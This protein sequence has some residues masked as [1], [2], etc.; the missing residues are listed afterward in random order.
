[1]VAINW[2]PINM[3]KQPTPRI[4]F[5]TKVYS[6]TYQEGEYGGH[7]LEANKHDQA[8]NP[9]A[10]ILSLRSILSLTKRVSMVAINWKP[11]NMTDQLTP[12]IYS[13][14]KVYS[15][16]YQEG[17]YGGHQLEANKHDRPT[18]TAHLFYH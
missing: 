4:Y 11:I 15:I 18:H 1:M 12:R 10:F 17:E 9:R 3:T 16:T 7:Q 6:I 8:T 2:K 5:I 13:I 14:T